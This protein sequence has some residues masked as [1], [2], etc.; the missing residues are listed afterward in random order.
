M[1][2]ED[3]RDLSMRL[4]DAAAKFRLPALP[5]V[6]P[7]WMT[8]EK[9]RSMADNFDQYSL[10]IDA[11]LSRVDRGADPDTGLPRIP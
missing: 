2:D 4:S 7:D 6:W 11:M 3:I 8:P 10:E 1:T 9:R 5:G